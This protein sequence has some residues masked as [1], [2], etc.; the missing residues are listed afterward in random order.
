MEREDDLEDKV[1]AA[2]E[3]MQAEIEELE[4][5]ESTLDRDIEN[6]ESEWRRKQEDPNV[7]GADPDES[8]SS[9]SDED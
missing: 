5:H 9:G 7:P 4:H 1:Q 3:E 2:A 8:T 6:T